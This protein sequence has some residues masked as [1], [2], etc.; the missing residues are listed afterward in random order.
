M[1]K[2]GNMAKETQSSFAY[3]SCNIKQAGTIQDFV[4]GDEVVP[5]NVQDAPLAPHTEEAQSSPVSL[6]S[7]ILLM[8][9]LL[10]LLLLIG[11]VSNAK[12]IG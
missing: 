4:V 11:P 6:Q 9:L 3:N 10:L 2:S 1:W 5:A 12:T 8:L 7:L